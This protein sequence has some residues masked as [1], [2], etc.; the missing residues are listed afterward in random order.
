M[1]LFFM[2]VAM[3]TDL[4]PLVE[5]PLTI[6]AA[7][8]AVIALKAAVVVAAGWLTRQPAGLSLRMGLALCQAGEF[9]FILLA[10]GRASGVVPTEL[11]SEISL[12]IVGTMA[13]TSILIPAGAW[14]AGG[15]ERR[16]GSS[17]DELEKET[18]DLADH[19]IVAGFGRVGRTVTR[20]LMQQQ[21]PV[22]ALDVDAEGVRRAR[23]SG[24]P[25]YF[26]DATRPDVLRAVGAERAR[27]IVLTL[28]K[29]HMLDRF[30]ALLRWRFPQ[31]AIYARARDRGHAHRLLET[32]ATVSIPETFEAS[33][34]LAQEVMTAHGIPEDVVNRAV[35]VCRVEEFGAAP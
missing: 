32:G 27:A 29:T 1:A 20:L 23:E 6:A 35:N 2:S 3:A 18:I 33:L 22:L 4:S 11:I 24:L 9:G 15:L 12:V 7:V 5:R 19:V 21:I 28:D 13:L 10:L 34:R 30:I 31:L 16:R 14:M 26:G 25:V 17:V 8:A